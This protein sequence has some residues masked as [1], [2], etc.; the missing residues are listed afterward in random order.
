MKTV[1]KKAILLLTISSLFLLAAGCSKDNSQEQAAQ[2]GSE[3]NPVT[4]DSTAKDASTIN[5]Q[6]TA[7]DGNTITLTAWPSGGNRGPGNGEN[8]GQRPNS[9]SKNSDN[10]TPP[11][12]SSDANSSG[13]TGNDKNS[14][15][16]APSGNTQKGSTKMPQGEEKTITV[17]DS[18]TYSVEKDGKATTGSLADVTTGSMITVE[19]TTDSSGNEV[20]SVI[21]VRSFSRDGMMGRS[22]SNSDSQTGANNTK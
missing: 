15:R 3:N 6:V 16:P 9:D 4:A 12:K 13:S 20:P 19:F 5:G 8:R 18:T 22:N 1:K 2:T 14:N 7:V 17:T 10:I 21:T 11:D